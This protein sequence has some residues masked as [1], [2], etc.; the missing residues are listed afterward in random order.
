LYWW[1]IL[2]RNNIFKFVWT[3]GQ[4]LSWNWANKYA[5]IYLTIKNP[6]LNNWYRSL[7]D[8]NKI[9]YAL[10]ILFFKIFI[11][12]IIIHSCKLFFIFYFL[13]AHQNTSSIITE[14]Y[15]SEEKVGSQVHKQPQLISRPPPSTLPRVCTMHL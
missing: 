11:N 7:F 5:L 9:L 1:N 4:F 15:L 12:I 2:N 8:P 13:L 3:N 14:C 10:M 6:N